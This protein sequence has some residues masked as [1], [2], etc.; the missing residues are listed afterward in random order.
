MQA[1]KPNTK[2]VAY[3]GLYNGVTIIMSDKPCALTA[4]AYMIMRQ[5]ILDRQQ[6]IDG[7]HFYLSRCDEFTSIV[8]ELS[9]AWHEIRPSKPYP[10]T[11]ADLK[12]LHKAPMLKGVSTLVAVVDDKG[13]SF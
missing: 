10:T 8:K 4:L 9:A 5:R 13:L 12:K 2:A 3:A 1:F 7:V 6:A 11:I